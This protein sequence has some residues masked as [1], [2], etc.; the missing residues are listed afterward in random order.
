MKQPTTV[1]PSADSP[2]GVASFLREMVAL[3]KCFIAP[4]PFPKISLP[5][6]RGQI[7][8]LI[9]G[10]LAGDWTMKRLDRFLSGRGYRVEYAGIALNLGPTRTLVR[11]LELRLGRLASSGPVIVI[12]QSFGGVL[13]RGLSLR[14]GDKIRL[15]ITMGTP[16]RFPVITPLTPFARML[17]WLHDKSWLAMRNAIGTPTGVPTIA[18]YS[19]SDGYVDW[20]QCLQNPVPECS[21]VAVRGAHTTL[22]SNPQTQLAIAHALACLGESHP[23]GAAPFQ[24]RGDALGSATSNNERAC[25]ERHCGHYR[26]GNPRQSRQSHRRGRCHS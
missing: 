8:M 6:G 4:P 17:A 12:G 25:H 3:A 21:N 24:Q 26:A 1:F 13:A 15:L 14:H 18:I 20:H 10:F 22:G 11:R 2:V 7:V 9:P 23:A 16:I 19:E 5:K